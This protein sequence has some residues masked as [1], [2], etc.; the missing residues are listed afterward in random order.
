[1]STADTT[2]HSLAIAHRRGAFAVE[3]DDAQEINGWKE[4]LRRG[5][6]GGS[7]TSGCP[8]IAT[9]PCGK[10]AAE[11]GEERGEDRQRMD[12]R[13]RGGGT[14]AGF[15]EEGGEK[16]AELW[17]LKKSPIICTEDSL[18]KKIHGGE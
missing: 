10:D 7:S 6:G 18:G 17:G 12:R 13:C 1:M 16:V 4:K 15:G 14:G 9:V 11:E 3:T 8:A 2:T 5:G